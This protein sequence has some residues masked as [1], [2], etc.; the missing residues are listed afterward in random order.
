MDITAKQASAD[1]NPLTGTPEGNRDSRVRRV[2]TMTGAARWIRLVRRSVIALAI[3]ALLPLPSLADAPQQ[4]EAVAVRALRWAF[5]AS[6][7]YRWEYSGI[8]VIHDGQLR[9]SAS[10]NTLKQVDAVEMD[11]EKQ[12]TPGDTLV[13][14]YHTHPCKSDEYFPQYFSPQDLVSAFFYHVPTFILDECTGEVHEFDP[15]RDRAA[16]T[17]T[18]V[19]VVRKDGTRTW[20]R[21]PAGRVVGDIGDRGPDLTLIEQLM[22]DTAE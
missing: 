10:P 20:V 19:R 3:A 17:G 5:Y 22:S 14:I 15:L 18:V 16:D 21:L 6:N 4:L 11:V 13:G 7:G 9:Y 12:R 1:D 8:L 2:G